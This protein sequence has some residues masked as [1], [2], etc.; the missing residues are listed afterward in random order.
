MKRVMLTVGYGLILFSLLGVVT[1]RAADLF[2]AIPDEGAVKA[3]T[4]TTRND[5]AK[6]PVSRD[7]ASPDTR[8]NIESSM[9]YGVMTRI[10]NR[11]FPGHYGDAGRFV[12]FDLQISAEVRPGSGDK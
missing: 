5:R 2:D 11:P 12:D 10:G 7:D 6:E 1:A 9:T 4:G 3:E 8:F